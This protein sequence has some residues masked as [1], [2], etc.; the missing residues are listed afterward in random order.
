M[1]VVANLSEDAVVWY[2]FM[3][4]EHGKAAYRDIL[5]N[6][7]KTFYDQQYKDMRVH[8]H[9]NG[10]VE[11]ATLVGQTAKGLVEI[12]FLLVATVKDD[13]IARIEEYFDSTIGHDAG[14]LD[15]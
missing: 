6:S 1:T 2:N 8:Y 11:Q 9:P 7:K 4:G 15:G 12:P 13:K 14:L 3:P 5:E 10:F